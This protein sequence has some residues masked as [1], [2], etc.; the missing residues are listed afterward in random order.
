[1]FGFSI[2]EHVGLTPRRSPPE[3]SGQIN[4]AAWPRPVAD[5]PPR[6]VR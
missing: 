3:N 5:L 4:D 6:L 1:V 2:F